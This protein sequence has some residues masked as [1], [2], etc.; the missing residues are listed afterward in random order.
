MSKEHYTTKEVGDKFG[1]KK[2]TIEDWIRRG[3]LT[4]T[5]VG[6]TIIITQDDLDLFYLKNKAGMHKKLKLLT[7]NQEEA[8]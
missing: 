5:K 3:W 4:A 6:K 2:R 8:E 1:R 7:P